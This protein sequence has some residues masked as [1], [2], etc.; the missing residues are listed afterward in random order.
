MHVPAARLRLRLVAPVSFRERGGQAAAREHA[1]KIIVFRNVFGRA[2]GLVSS[3]GGI[4]LV[5]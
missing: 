3:V 2:A 4:F 5:L 1:V